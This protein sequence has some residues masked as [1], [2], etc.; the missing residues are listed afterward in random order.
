MPLKSGQ[1][2]YYPIPGCW[3]ITLKS[4]CLHAGKYAPAKGN[5]Y[6]YAPLKGEWADIIR[7]VLQRSVAHS[8]IPQ[9][10]VQSLIWGILARAKIAD[11]PASLKIAAARLLT[12]KEIFI[13]DG[14]ALGLIPRALKEEA[15][16]VLPPTVRGVLKVEATLRDILQRGIETYKD[17]GRVA[18]RAGIAPRQEGD[19]EVPASRWSYHPDGYFV[20][21]L[22][23]GHTRTTLQISIPRPYFLRFD[24]QN[25]LVSVRDWR[26]WSLEIQYDDNIMPLIQ[27]KDGQ[28]IAYVFRSLKLTMVKA[29]Q[30]KLTKE[31]S[32]RGWTLVFLPDQGERISRKSQEYYV[33]FDEALERC[34]AHRNQIENLLQQAPQTP[35]RE[36]ISEMT[37]RLGCLIYATENFFEVNSEMM[38]IREWKKRPSSF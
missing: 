31:W 33:Q 2:K 8:E 24:E 30:Q 25:R 15:F 27:E 26:G 1:I 11:M 21:F 23:S 32:G 9:T 38:A 37:T 12:A 22:P 14:G 13:V 3:T 5:G 34:R 18:V 6:L 29:K 7:S 19:R 36:E 10:T 20:R 35:L 4:Y 17:L 16:R 28:P